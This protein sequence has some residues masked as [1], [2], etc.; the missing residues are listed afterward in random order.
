MPL[1]HVKLVEGAFSGEQK[2]ALL[3][4]ITDAVEE[5]HPG[6]RDVTF[7]TIEEVTGG[8]WSIGGEPV[9][10]ERVAQHARE[11]LGG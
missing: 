8:E 2:R 10:A 6:L 7:V 4:K 11:Q 3:P 1:I 5:V 9:D